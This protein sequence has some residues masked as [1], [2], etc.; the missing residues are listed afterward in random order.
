MIFEVQI[1]GEKKQIHKSKLWARRMQRVGSLI[2][3]D[4]TNV[5]F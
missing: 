5:A 3:T 4:S 2:A 1:A